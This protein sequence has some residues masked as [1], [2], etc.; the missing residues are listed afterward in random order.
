ML[1]SFSTNRQSILF[2]VLATA[3]T[4]NQASITHRKLIALAPMI[5]PLAPFSP[6]FKGGPGRVC[7]GGTVCQG[8]SR[9]V[10]EGQ[11]IELLDAARKEIE[12]NKA[13]DATHATAVG[14][15]PQ[16]P[17]HIATGFVDVVMCQP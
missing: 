11:R 3:I 2:F 17:T 8:L 5:F 14:I 10:F 7:K 16:G 13:L 15:L 4:I 1:I 12:V 9:N 6:P